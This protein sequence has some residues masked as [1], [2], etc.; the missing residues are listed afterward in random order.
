VTSS[1]VLVGNDK[2]L[3]SFCAHGEY[4]AT[5]QK[6]SQRKAEESPIVFTSHRCCIQH[7]AGVFPSQGADCGYEKQA[8]LDVMGRVAEMEIHS[9]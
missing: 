2:E 8:I 4:L 7:E 9:L 3:C 6:L 5:L 1:P